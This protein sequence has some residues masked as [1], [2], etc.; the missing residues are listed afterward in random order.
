MKPPS[1]VEN[2]AIPNELV[3]TYHAEAAPATGGSG[4]SGRELKKRI[5]EEV[6]KFLVIL[7]AMLALFSL[8]KTIVL[9]QSHMDYQSQSFAIINALILAKV[10][11]VAE[12]LRLGNKSGTMH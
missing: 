6:K 8:H 9:E 10:V 11:L 1:A 7:W 3:R 2:S 12:D 4:K 5:G